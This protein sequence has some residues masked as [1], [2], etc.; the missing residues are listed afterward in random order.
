M[1]QKVKTIKKAWFVTI[2]FL[3]MGFKFQDSV[4]NVYHDLAV[5]CLNISN[6]DIITVK[7]VAYRYII[8]SISKSEAVHL[9]K[10]SV[11]EDREY[12]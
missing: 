12:T 7:G 8:L 4:C 2:G 6:I 10:K 1:L 9:L 5:L 11:L 3:I